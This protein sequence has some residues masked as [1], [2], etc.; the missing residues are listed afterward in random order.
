MVLVLQIPH[1]HVRPPFCYKE[2][3][4]QRAYHTSRKSAKWFKK[5]KGRQ[6]DRHADRY[7]DRQT[8]RHTHTHFVHSH[9]PGSSYCYNYL[10]GKRWRR[11]RP[12][13]NL[14]HFSGQTENRHENQSRQRVSD[15]GTSI[16]SN[17]C[18][19]L[20]RSVHLYFMNHQSLASTSTTITVIIR[21]SGFCDMWQWQLYA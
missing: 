17:K 16:I 9:A 7:T 13:P 11:D 10:N 12:W 1:K 14:G 20:D 6:T 5:L 8:D 19:E 18:Y 2:L 21:R 15:P 3:L 4:A